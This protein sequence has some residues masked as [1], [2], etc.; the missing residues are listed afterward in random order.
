[1]KPT[2]KPPSNKRRSL[3]SGRNI[4]A[5]TAK[6]ALSFPLDDF[7]KLEHLRKQLNIS[8]SQFVLQ[9]VRR[10]F[11]QIEREAAVAEYVRGYQQ[12][13][14]EKALTKVMESAQAQTIAEEIW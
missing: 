11:E 1:M 2:S 13:P 5:G 12:I 6:F 7:A 3:N 9:S 10:W 4:Q 14:E 8:R